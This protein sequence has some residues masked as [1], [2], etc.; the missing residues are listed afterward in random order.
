M[1]K[2]VIMMM[3]LAFVGA[4]VAIAAD[5]YTYEVEKGT[6]T[7]DH[8]AHQDSLGDC[9]KCHEGEPAKIEVDKDFGHKTCKTCH[10][11][12]KKGPTKCNDCHKK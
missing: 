1:K 4:N 5:S 2:L 9:A 8:K 11:E 6:V 10:K 7:F 3:L 12:M